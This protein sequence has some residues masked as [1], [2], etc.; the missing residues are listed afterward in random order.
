[1][2]DS[3]DVI[4]LEQSELPKAVVIIG[5]EGQRTVYEMKPAGTGK[6]GA[7]LAGVS[8]FVRQLILGKVDQQ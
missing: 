4:V 1:M 5:G 2:R 7:C 6:V 3:G 8:A